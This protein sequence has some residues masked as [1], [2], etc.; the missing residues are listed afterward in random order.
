M[1]S[2]YLAVA[3][4]ALLVIGVVGFA[5]VS[6]VF[7]AI[8]IRYSVAPL[9]KPVAAWLVSEARGWATAPA[10]RRV[11][12]VRATARTSRPSR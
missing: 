1:D 8:A 10:P 4:I 9:L 3:G 6:L 12:V 5:L 11:A 2:V 7:A